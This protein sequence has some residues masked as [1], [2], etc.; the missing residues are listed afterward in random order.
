VQITSVIYATRDDFEVRVCKGPI[1][2]VWTYWVIRKKD[3]SIEIRK[4]GRVN[5]YCAPCQTTEYDI[6]L[7]AALQEAEHLGI[8]EV[9]D[10]LPYWLT[11]TVQKDRIG[12]P[13]FNQNNYV[14]APYIP[15]Q[16]PPPGGTA[17]N[18]ITTK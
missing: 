10:P 3:L 18:I 11:V 8:T 15:M 13:N 4:G 6:Y 9:E 16:V 14:F 12:Q 5:K 1:S 2:D 7:M 17:P